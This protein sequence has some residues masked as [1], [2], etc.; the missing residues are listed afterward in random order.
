MKVI[1]LIG[2]CILLQGC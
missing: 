1:S 2:G